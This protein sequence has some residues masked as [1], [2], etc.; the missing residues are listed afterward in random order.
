MGPEES[1]FPSRKRPIFRSFT[2][3]FRQGGGLNI[4]TVYVGII[5]KSITGIIRIPITLSP[6][7][8]EV[9]NYP[10]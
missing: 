3:R 6:T 5:K 2:V 7:I 8:V 1:L 4:Y 9:E 10:K